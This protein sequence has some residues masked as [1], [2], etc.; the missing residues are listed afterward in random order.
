MNGKRREGNGIPHV[1]YK[2]DKGIY[3]KKKITNESYKLF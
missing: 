3:N 2:Q 1:E